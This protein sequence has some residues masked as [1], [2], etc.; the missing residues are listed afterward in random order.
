LNIVAFQFLSPIHRASRQIGRHL[1]PLMGRLGLSNR[2]AH[3]LSYLSVYGPCAVG[4]LHTVFSHPRST[5][6]SMLDRL[7]RNGLVTREIRLEDRRSFLVGLTQ[8]GHQRAEL[9]RATLLRLEDRIGTRLGA[10]DL[11][12]FRTVLAAI[13]DAT[14]RHEEAEEES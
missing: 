13:A 10:R 14:S 2:E 1:E 8:T 4:V 6:T 7:E 5:L 3:V 12:G 11:E 9:V